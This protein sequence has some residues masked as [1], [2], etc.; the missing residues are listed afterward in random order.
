LRLGNRRMFT[1]D[2]VLRLAGHLKVEI[3]HHRFCKFPASP[4]GV[5]A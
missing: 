1:S 4:G 3:V 5:R 2:D